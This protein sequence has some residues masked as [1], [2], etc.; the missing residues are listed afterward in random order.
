MNRSYFIPFGNTVQIIPEEKDKNGVCI[1]TVN[2]VGASVGKRLDNVEKVLYYMENVIEF[3]EFHYVYHY[4]IRAVLTKPR[5]QKG[6]FKLDDKK[7]WE[8]INFRKLDI[9]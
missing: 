6:K 1:G 3:G 2:M 8:N 4:H 5:K 9:I 7:N